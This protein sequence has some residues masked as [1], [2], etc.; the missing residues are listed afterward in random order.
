MKKEVVQVLNPFL[1]FVVSFQ[2]AKTHNMLCMMLEA[3]YKGLGLAIQF[4]GKERAWQIV[5]QYDR[6]VLLS[7][8]VF[9]YNF[10]N[11]SDAGVKTPSFTSDIIE[12]TSLLYNLMKIDEKMTSSMVKE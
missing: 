8:L 1:S 4:L 2:K 10:L 12:I 11:P 9:A 5:S 6:W 3:C 7:L